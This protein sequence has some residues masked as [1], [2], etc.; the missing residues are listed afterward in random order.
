MMRK[1]RF[2]VIGFVLWSL[3]PSIPHAAE[4]RVEG[5]FLEAYIETDTGCF[6]QYFLK[7]SS[8]QLIEL[9]LKP[10][11]IGTIKSG[12]NVVV[13][14][15][16][17]DSSGRSQISVSSI[18]ILLPPG[19]V[20]SQVSSHPLMS[21]GKSKI[22]VILF[23]FLNNSDQT[24]T[25]A[26]VL[27]RMNNQ[28][29]PWLESVS[30]GKLDIEDV[31]VFGYLTIP[32]DADCTNP[33]FNTDFSAWAVQAIAASGLDLSSY[34]QRIYYSPVRCGSVAGLA[35]VGGNVCMIYSAPAFRLEIVDHELGHNLGMQHANALDCGGVALKSPVSLCSSIEYGDRYDMMGAGNS[36]HYNAARLQEIQWISD[37]EVQLAA[38]SGDYDIGPLEI[39]ATPKK[40]LKIPVTPGSTTDFYFLEYRQ[41]LAQDVNIST[42]VLNGVL[43][44]VR[45]SSY[46]TTLIDTTPETHDWTDAALNVGTSFT[47]PSGIRMTPLS[48]DSNNIR[49]RVEFNAPLDPGTVEFAAPSYQV[50]EESSTA[51]IYVGRFGSASGA[52]SVSYATSDGTAVQGADYTTQSGI[53]AF[54]D[55]EA[56]LKPI[57]IPILNDS[58]L[59]NL[60]NFTVTLSNPTGDIRLGS[61][62]STGITISDDDSVGTVRFSVPSASV[63]ENVS[64]F[65]VSVLRENGRK[66]PISLVYE[67]QEGSALNGVDFTPTTGPLVFPDQNNS[68]KTISIPILDDT[69]MEPNKQFTVRL[70]SAPGDANGINLSL[71][72]V[73]KDNES[74]SNGPVAAAVGFLTFKN[75]FNPTKE[76]PMVILYT[77]AGG[78]AELTIYDKNGHEI[79]RLSGSNGQASWDGR[80][81]SGSVVAS[82]TYL[83]VLKQAGNVVKEK[84]AVVK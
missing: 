79:Q 42:K 23:N 43:L 75:A 56:G 49:I 5:Q 18:T 66:G 15:E 17:I 62:T 1:H 64:P 45:D 83:V 77:Q 22:A 76:P 30:Y 47:T 41:R 68:P 40:L 11:M 52:A 31:D 13:L 14:G 81:A 84:V 44:R 24:L 8:G 26:T 78:P 25:E 12:N 3:C 73:I 55:N 32:R 10:G 27:D 74:P 29:V 36:A 46:R 70:R 28:M 4:S 58:V 65:T 2:W 39:A 6:P 35:W 48:N 60:E 51:T 20:P 33:N 69:Q 80:N 82:G 57:T 53:V 19:V 9:L 38:Q 34:E 21:N 50:N 63:N 71:P 59:E 37:G 72:V 67:T 61:R 54:A 7:I 16:R